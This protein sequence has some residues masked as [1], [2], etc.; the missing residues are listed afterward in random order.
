MGADADD[1][2]IAAGHFANH[3]TDF[4]GSDIQAD[5]DVSLS[6]SLQLN[7][8]CDPKMTDQAMPA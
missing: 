1:I 7:P 6:C 4:G 3:G 5:N 2:D 8:P